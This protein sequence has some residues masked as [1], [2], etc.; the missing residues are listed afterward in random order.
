MKI[1]IYQLKTHTD[2][3]L[4]N[5]QLAN[6]GINNFILVIDGEVW[7]QDLSKTRE[8]QFLKSCISEKYVSINPQIFEQLT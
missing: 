4:E 7:A 8:E 6:M 5:G 1:T 2:I 3:K